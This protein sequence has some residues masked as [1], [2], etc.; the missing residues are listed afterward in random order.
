MWKQKKQ[1]SK[2]NENF[3]INTYRFYHT[4]PL[5]QCKEH[6]Q[7]KSNQSTIKTETKK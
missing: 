3:A 2:Q 6:N 1:W 7:F 4:Y 5:L